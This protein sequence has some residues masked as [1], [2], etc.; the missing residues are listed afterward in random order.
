MAFKSR[1]TFLG[2][3]AVATTTRVQAQCPT[4]LWS[5]EFDGTA[6]DETKWTPMLGDGC[7]LGICGW[8][9]NEWQSY[10]D[11]AD[12]IEVSDGTLKIRATQNGDTYASARLRSID[13]ADF[14]MSKPSR[15]EARIKVPKNSQG[16]W[17]AFWMMPSLV[18][19]NTWP[20][21]GEIDIMEF[22]GREPNMVRT[23]DM[24]RERGIL[25][26]L[27]ILY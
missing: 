17:P 20:K 6:L 7:D 27:A 12:N 8:G 2:F 10:T 18:E 9:N 23:H 11:S 25:L 16:L 13:K 21:G 1:L 5:D 14:D 4:L 19:M 3:L 22:I 26:G 24:W 15:I